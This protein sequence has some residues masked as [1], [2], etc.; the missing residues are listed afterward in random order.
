MATACLDMVIVVKE[1][2]MP[3]ISVMRKMKNAISELD[4]TPSVSFVVLDVDFVQVLV[5]TRSQ[6][7]SH[8]LLCQR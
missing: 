7:C 8:T 5:H 6:C 3:T 2:A 1:V 4:E